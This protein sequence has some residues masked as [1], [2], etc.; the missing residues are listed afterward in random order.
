MKKIAFA[1]V[2]AATFAVVPAFAQDD[3]SGG[4]SASASASAAPAAAPAAGGEK[5][6]GNPG[7]INVGAATALDFT[8]SSI[9]PPSGDST[10]NTHFGLEANVSYFVAE[11]ISVGGDVLFAYD[12]PKDV[13]ATTTWGIGPIVGYNL[14]LTPGQLSLWPQVEL[15]YKS[16][17]TNITVGTTSTSATETVMNV[18]V[19]VP[20]LI[21]PVKHFHFGIGP[22]F[23][24]DVSSKVSVSGNSAD[25]NK[26]TNFGIKAEI[27]GWL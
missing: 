20:L 14:W 11:G 23:S 27:A 24:T 13:D 2:A 8:S 10:S 6:F 12:K 21:H 4:A 17:S 22:Y 3:A 19:W 7:T 15:L 18:G 1:F 5:E 9:K 26:T 25:G 16:S